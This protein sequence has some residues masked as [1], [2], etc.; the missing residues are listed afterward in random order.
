MA[1]YGFV[2]VLHNPIMPGI[3]KIGYT[4]RSPLQ[5]ADDLS[6]TSIPIPYDVVCYGE[7]ENPI[8]L[9]SDLHIEYKEHRVAH[10]RE[11][12]RLTYLELYRLA[13]QIQ[14]SCINFTKCQELDII[15]SIHLT[16][17]EKNAPY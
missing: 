9:E 14:E 5:R 16:E 12:F 10:N 15:E 4:D 2:Y 7:I 8:S 17:E 13:K 3:Y 6:N 1:S 11:F